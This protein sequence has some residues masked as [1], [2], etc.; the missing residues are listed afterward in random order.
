MPTRAL[1]DE[2]I[3]VKDSSTFS[4]INAQDAESA[5]QLA[6][7]TIEERSS[8]SLGQFQYRKK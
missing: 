8:N 3:L 7:K 4:S 2:E 6:L 5:L 1:A